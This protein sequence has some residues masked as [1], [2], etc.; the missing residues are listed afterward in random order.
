M[1]TKG[2]TD[3]EFSALLEWV[4]R[5]DWLKK[6]IISL[7]KHNTHD[8]TVTD[9]EILTD[10]YPIP[11]LVEIKVEEDVFMPETKNIALDFLSSFSFKDG[12]KKNLKSYKWNDL[13]KMI[14][15]SKYGTLIDSDADIIIKKLKGTSNIFVYNN[16]ILTS[17]H[18][19]KYVLDNYL[20]KIN[21]KKQYD[22]D[23]NWESAFI[24]VS[25][26]DKELNKALIL[27]EKPFL[28]V[29]KHKRENTYQ[30]AFDYF[31]ISDQ[32]QKTNNRFVC[33]NNNG[34]YHLCDV[35]CAF[36]PDKPSSSVIYN[37]QQEAL[38]NNKFPCKCVKQ[39]LL[40]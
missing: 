33:Y 9:A 4:Q 22:L 20:V 2:Y 24:C 17:H 26:F 13:A 15:V 36:I 35:S 29:Y 3:D 38:L 7:K 5:N 34:F 14:D 8:V 27:G 18:F 28:Q 10:F 11:L 19:V 39:N 21:P 25:L 1:N 6:H 30:K 40:P 16:H 23:D 32:L 37:S 31:H 12:F